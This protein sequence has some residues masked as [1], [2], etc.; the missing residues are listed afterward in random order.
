MPPN[1]TSAAPARGITASMSTRA[2]SA[3]KRSEGSLVWTE[4][5]DSVWVLVEVVAQDNTLLRV[6]NKK[7]GGIEEIDLVS[8]YYTSTVLVPVYRTQQHF[9]SS[10]CLSNACTSYFVYHDALQVSVTLLLCLLLYFVLRSCSSCFLDRV[11]HINQPKPLSPFALFACVFCLVPMA[12][13][14]A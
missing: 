6:L 14:R 4:N 1:I 3:K 12:A 9:Y 7:T 13:V 10:S 11:R 8:M 2:F 5:P